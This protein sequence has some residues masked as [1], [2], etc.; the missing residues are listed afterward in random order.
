MT[1]KPFDFSNFDNAVVTLCQRNE[2]IFMTIVSCGYLK[3]RKKSQPE[4]C[5]YTVLISPEGNIISVWKGNLKDV[6]SKINKERPLTFS[7][8]YNSLVGKPIKT[9]LSRLEAWH[10]IE[11]VGINGVVKLEFT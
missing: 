10:T 8:P 7:S 5:N 1:D 2:N 3:E 11:K 9:L 4:I 6:Y